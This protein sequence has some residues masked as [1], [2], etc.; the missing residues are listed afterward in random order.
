[1]NEKLTYEE[2]LAVLQ[3]KNLEQYRIE[4]STRSR[5]YDEAQKYIE[6]PV[7]KWPEI[8]MNW[9]VSIEGQRYCFD[10]MSKQEFLKYYPDNLCLGT[11]MLHDFDK[12]LCHFSRRD[13]SE[14][15]ELGSQTKLAFLIVYLSENLPI[16]PPVAKPTDNNEVIFTGGH[17]RYAVAKSIGEG[18]IPICVCPE[19]KSGIDEII[20]VTWKHA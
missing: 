11:V 16:S 5:I 9:D 19:H 13:G 4:S 2:H 7:N 15:W 6:L 8:N 1:M 18:N 17:H 20:N 14:L 12:K 10:G 3:G